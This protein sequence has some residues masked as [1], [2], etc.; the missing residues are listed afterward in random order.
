[1]IIND[2]IRNDDL[3]S[4]KSSRPIC[5]GPS[6]PIE[7][8]ACEPT[9]LRFENEIAAILI[10][11]TAREKKTANVLKK[12]NNLELN[13]DWKNMKKFFDMKFTVGNINQD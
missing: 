7:T 11:S 3:K 8:P 5:D 9:H 13:Y 2:K 12:I 6:S 10:W 4:A 1:M